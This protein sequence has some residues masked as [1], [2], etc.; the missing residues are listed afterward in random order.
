MTIFVILPLVNQITMM[1]SS[2]IKTNRQK[3]TLYF[4]DVLL[5]VAG[6]VLQ[7]GQSDLCDIRVGHNLPVF[8]LTYLN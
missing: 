1:F 4:H 2:L 7:L 6:T 5:D 8:K 3:K